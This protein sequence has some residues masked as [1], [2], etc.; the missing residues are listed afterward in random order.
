MK[1]QCKSCKK[2]HIDGEWTTERADRTASAYTYCPTC[3][4]NIQD[5][6]PSYNSTIGFSESYTTAL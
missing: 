1:V 4:H 2:L 3:Y 6:S 5:E